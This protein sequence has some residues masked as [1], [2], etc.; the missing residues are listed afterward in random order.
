MSD[1]LNVDT[2]AIADMVAKETRTSYANMW[3]KLREE[4]QVLFDKLTKEIA[5]EYMAYAFGPPEQKAAHEA[6]LVSLRNGL[7]ALE[8]V[9]AIRTY[10]TTIALV[11]RIMANLLKETA[12]A[13][14][15]L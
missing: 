5:R 11:G 3:S 13:A 1:K 4:Q 6:N 2:S 15:G 12:K 8:G 10:R 7:A 14:I 9:I